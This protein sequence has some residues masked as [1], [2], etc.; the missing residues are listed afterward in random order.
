M[1]NEAE[2][3]QENIRLKEENASMKNE[4]VRQAQELSYYK[5]EI[6]QLKR[7]IFGSKS[8]RYITA[9]ESQLSLFDLEKV[10]EK[11]PE[12]EEI[13]YSRKKGPKK[14]KSIPI[15]VALPSHLP[16]EEHVIQPDQDVSQAKKIG[17]EITEILEYKPGKIFVKKYIRPK[18]ALPKEKGIAIGEL[19]SLPIPRGNAG[20]G[21]L[22]HL[23][24][25]KYVDHLPYYR[26]VQQF[27]RQGIELSESTINDWFSKVCKLLAPLDIKLRQQ[28]KSADYLMAD[29]TPIAVLSA[30]KPGS[31]HR[32]YY[33]VYYSPILKLVSFDYREGRG[34]EGPKGYLKNFRGALQT[35]GYSAYKNF[36]H[37]K[38][39]TLLACMAHARRKFDQALKNDWK[40][41]DYALKKIQELYD[42]ERNVREGQFSYN[43]R[44]KLREEESIPVLEELENWLLDQKP[45]VL[46]K[47]AIGE[48]INY[49]LSLW[50]RLKRYVNDG[51][52]EID[53]N[54]V[55]N[56]I[57]PVAL[58]RKNYLFA[59]SH[60]GA[61]RAALIYSFL[62]SCK[63]N[64]IDPYKWLND[65]L[66]RILDH[67]ANKLDE[68]LPGNWEP[69]K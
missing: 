31:T 28:L 20:P 46:P 7:M 37:N 54:L 29:E 41:A 52:Y 6:D 22:T 45:E 8:E 1:Q 63:M 33:W 32:G 30:D 51:K 67:K 42:I 44:K 38:N 21:L 58:G 5:Q 13:T 48:A 27:K 47:S 64:N 4:F 19:P 66:S 34:R 56:S 18:Y 3:I 14:E 36:E 53:N 62:G 40:R 10:E 23:I 55:E 60:D 65:V 15:R 39:I 25:S 57:R 35:D 12:K 59:G 43:G 68:L 16:R 61:K 2:I 11:Q 69:L 9:D 24:V 17:E 49:T 26:Q 50:H